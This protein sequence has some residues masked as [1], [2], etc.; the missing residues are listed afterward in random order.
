MRRKGNSQLWELCAEVAFEVNCMKRR[1]GAHESGERNHLQS[2]ANVSED[3]QLSEQQNPKL[4]QGSM[5]V[6]LNSDPGPDL[7][8]QKQ[9]KGP[10]PT[11]HCAGRVCLRS[12]GATGKT[13][14]LQISVRRVVQESFPSFFDV[15][16]VYSLVVISVGQRI[17]IVQ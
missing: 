8:E 9:S 15:S 6:D 4:A 2:P 12:S 17:D 16:L 10:F 1:P 7:V 5:T 3:S 14:C 11:G 13:Q